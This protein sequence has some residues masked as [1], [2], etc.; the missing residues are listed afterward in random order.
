MLLSA[1]DDPLAAADFLLC[2][3]E[4][5]VTALG[6]LPPEP[7]RHFRDRVADVAADL[8]RIAVQNPR[9]GEAQ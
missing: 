4:R 9:Q 7:I 1:H 6:A 8:N 3:I 5:D 2:D